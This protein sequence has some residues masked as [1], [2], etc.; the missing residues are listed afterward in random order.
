ML[1]ICHH[2]LFFSWLINCKASSPKFAWNRFLIGWLQARLDFD[3]LLGNHLYNFLAGTCFPWTIFQLTNQRLL[4]DFFNQSLSEFKRNLEMAPNVHAIR[5]MNDTH[6]RTK[7]RSVWWYVTW[8]RCDVY[9]AHWDRMKN[10]RFIIVTSKEFD[11]LRVC[12]RLDLVFNLFGGGSDFH[13]P[14]Y[15]EYYWVD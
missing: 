1:R 11:V 15:I 8:R 4:Q 13:I 2:N 14:F 12:G 7:T 6:A 3:W 10:I 5:K 9:E